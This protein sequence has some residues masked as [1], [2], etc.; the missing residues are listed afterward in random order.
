M[1]LTRIKYGGR[2][3]VEPWGAIIEL[4]NL[5]H[6]IEGNRLKFDLLWCKN[7][8]SPVSQGR[9]SGY[10]AWEGRYY[11]WESLRADDM[12]KEFVEVKFLHFEENKH[13]KHAFVCGTINWNN[14]LSDK[15]DFYYFENIVSFL[16]MY[17]CPSGPSSVS[18][19]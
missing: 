18:K 7:Q 19:V 13:G 8:E 14:R 10:A 16:E 6:F 5:T 12:A 4:I 1:E 15:Q 17:Y 2:L 11:A 9:V 3:L